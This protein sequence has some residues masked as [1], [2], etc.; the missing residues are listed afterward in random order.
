M[1]RLKT[2]LHNT[3]GQARLNHITQLQI[4]KE[5]LDSLDLA[6]IA[7]E[8]ACGREHRLSYFT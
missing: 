1:R 7:N 2:Y 6:L 3:I 8:F 4:H 5:Q